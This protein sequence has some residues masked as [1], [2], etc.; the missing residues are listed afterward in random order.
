MLNAFL[1]LH[2]K[3]TGQRP[4]IDPEVPWCC[5]FFTHKSSFLATL[6]IHL[7]EVVTIIT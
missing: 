6:E 1:T 7:I 3:S 4:T 2:S 5:V